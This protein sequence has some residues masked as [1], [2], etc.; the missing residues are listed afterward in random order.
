MTYRPTFGNSYDNY[1]SSNNLGYSNVSR[2]FNKISNR[3][4]LCH[5]QDLNE[6]QGGMN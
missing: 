1:M 4:N 5:E 2:G 3:S 6:E